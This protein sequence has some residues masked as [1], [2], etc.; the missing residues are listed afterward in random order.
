MRII[1]L[2]LAA[3]LLIGRLSFFLSFFTLLWLMCECVCG[4]EIERASEWERGRKKLIYLLQCLDK[5]CVCAELFRIFYAIKLFFL[6]SQFGIN[7][8]F[9]WNC[10]LKL[11]CKYPTHSHYDIFFHLAVI[12]LIETKYE[13]TKKTIMTT[14]QQNE[15]KNAFELKTKWKRNRFW[16]TKK[17]KQKWL[18]GN[19]MYWEPMSLQYQVHQH[20]SD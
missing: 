20:P 4:V 5:M 3:F 17:N 16:K 1:I 2:S 7:S 11:I 8:K 9:H 6:S 14:K 12:L 18:R 13:R 15:K 10:S 19:R